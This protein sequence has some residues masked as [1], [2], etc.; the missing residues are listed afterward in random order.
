MGGTCVDIEG[1][2]EAIEGSQPCCKAYK[3]SFWSNTTGFF[4]SLFGTGY[5]WV[6][7]CHCPEDEGAPRPT[8]KK[9]IRSFL[10]L[11]GY[12]QDFIPSFAA[13]A[14]PLSDLTCKGQGD[15]G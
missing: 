7:R 15:V 14:A 1:T 8:T 4:R 11:A 2:V 13:I 3:V 12:Y 9:E 5:D 6:T 10:G